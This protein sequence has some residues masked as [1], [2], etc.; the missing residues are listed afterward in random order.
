M[1]KLKTL[2]NSY[3]KI[4]EKYS[5]VITGEEVWSIAMEKI[6]EEAEESL[7]NEGCI[8]L[9]EWREHMRRDYNIAL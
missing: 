2:K 1:V 7:R 5:R 8:T 4:K 3:K 6:I 9:E